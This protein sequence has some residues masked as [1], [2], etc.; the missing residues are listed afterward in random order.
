MADTQARGDA[1]AQG[2]MAW[3]LVIREY[4]AADGRT[5]GPE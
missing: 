5:S 2:R 4:K 1:P 3:M